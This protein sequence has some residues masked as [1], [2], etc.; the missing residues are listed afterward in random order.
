MHLHIYFVVY[1]K[2][3][4]VQRISSLRNKDLTDGQQVDVSSFNAFLTEIEAAR[5][6]GDF[7]QFG[8]SEKEPCP[9]VGGFWMCFP[10][11]SLPNKWVDQ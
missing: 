2:S 1:L 6:R 8:Q 10:V 5:V 7:P 9:C 4:K 11:C 3:T